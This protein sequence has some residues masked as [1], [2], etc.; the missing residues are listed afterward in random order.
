MG[1]WKVS[2]SRVTRRRKKRYCRTRGWAL[3]SDV[4]G[5]VVPAGVGMGAGVEGGGESFSM[6]AQVR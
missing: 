4:G 1:R 5:S 6:R 3:R 2:V